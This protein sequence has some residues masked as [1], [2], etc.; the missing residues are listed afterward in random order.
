MANEV[1]RQ[2]L[3][4]EAVRIEKDRQH[5]I[6]NRKRRREHF[7]RL[8]TRM[9]VLAKVPEVDTKLTLWR[10]EIRPKLD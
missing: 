7:K 2:L 5:W 3:E 4:E 9:R 8:K 10:E 6:V 1:E